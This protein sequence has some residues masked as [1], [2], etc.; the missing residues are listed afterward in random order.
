MPKKSQIIP[1]EPENDIPIVDCHAHFPD[2]E[3]YRKPTHS[4]ENQYQFFF[5]KH[6]GQFIISSASLWDY[7]YIQDFIKTHENIY[8]TMG[9]GMPSDR[10]SS[11]NEAEEQAEQIEFLKVK[12]DNYIAIGEFGLDFHHAKSFEKR[13][14]QIE[15]F[16]RII[17]ETKHLDKPYVLHVR[18]PTERDKDPASPKEEYNERDI[19]NKII[20]ETLER[21]NIPPEKVMWHCFSGPTEDGPKLAEKGYFISIPSSAYGFNR[22]R[23][24]IKNVPLNK[25]LTETDSC[26]QHPFRMGG[27]NTPA[28]VR[29]TVAAI[30]YV[31]E[32]NQ[33][34]VAEQILLNAKEFFD[35]N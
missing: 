14:Q 33:S 8:M 24:N 21:E 22:W 12:T 9:C 16:Q 3:P 32:I 29:Y 2:K 7:E 23:R 31:N 13:E 11:P 4:Y 10:Y 19:C 25:L 26:F 15:F 1:I 34:K 30:A 27:F 28:N 35:I 20:L 5:E 6:N 18:N 17:K